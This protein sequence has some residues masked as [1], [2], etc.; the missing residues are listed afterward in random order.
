MTFELLAPHLHQT[1]LAARTYFAKEHGAKNFQIE[2]VV[3]AELSLKPTLSAQLSNG[4]ILC[5]EVSDKAYSNSLDTFVVECSG[6]CFPAKLF[7]PW[8]SAKGIRILP[9]I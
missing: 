8:P 1:A 7:W 2:K 6:R 3:D 9:R 5:V 4:C